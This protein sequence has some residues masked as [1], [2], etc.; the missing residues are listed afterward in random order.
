MFVTNKGQP[1][2]QATIPAIIV[3]SGLFEDELIFINVQDGKLSAAFHPDDAGILAPSHAEEI[4]QEAVK[5]ATKAIQ[6]GDLYEFAGPA[7]E[8]IVAF[9]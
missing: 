1:L 3:H 5:V 6:E 9:R 4:L 8:R 7:H 2:S